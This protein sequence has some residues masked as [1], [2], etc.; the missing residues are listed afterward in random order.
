[1]SIVVRCDAKDNA[2][3]KEIERSVKIVDFAQLKT[4]RQLT[5]GDLVITVLTH[6]AF[7]A[8]AA[9]EVTGSLG[10][11]TWGK[12]AGRGRRSRNS[13]T[14]PWS[15]SQ[16]KKKG[17]PRGGPLRIVRERGDQIASARPFVFRRNAA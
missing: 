6:K 4:K 12:F 13:N 2:I 15:W 3:E 1:M 8:I 9:E 14:Y 16:R 17:P 11:T 7:A 5:P 10:T